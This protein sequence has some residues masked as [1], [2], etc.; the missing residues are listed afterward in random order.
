VHTVDAAK[1]QD[2]DFDLSHI[3]SD[4]ARLLANGPEQVF[5]EKLK[6]LLRLGRISSRGKDVFDM[7]YLT[8]HVKPEGLKP[9]FEAFIYNDP[10]MLE[11]RTADMTR[12]LQ[13]IFSDRGFMALLRNRRMN[14][15]QI[16]PEEATERILTFLQTM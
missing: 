15:L 5:V 16:T 4:A 9:L 6:S 12:R 2:M 14:W 7:A 10:K 1:Q 11:K 13:R 8:D 3:E